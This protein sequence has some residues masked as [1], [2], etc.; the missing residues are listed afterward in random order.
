MSYNCLYWICPFWWGIV[1]PPPPQT[2]AGM[3]SLLSEFCVQI[4]CW[5]C[6]RLV[7]GFFVFICRTSIRLTLSPAPCLPVFCPRPRPVVPCHKA[8]APGHDGG[9]APG[10]L[11]A[12]WGRAECAGPEGPG[13]PQAQALCLRPVPRRVVRMPRPLSFVPRPSVP[14]SVWPVRCCQDPNRRPWSC[15]QSKSQS[16][17]VT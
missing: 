11:F 14:R 5:L 2:T 17:L 9:G 16:D 1:L 7:S 3:R 8:I 15:H 12:V 13:H 10:V 6:C 4:F